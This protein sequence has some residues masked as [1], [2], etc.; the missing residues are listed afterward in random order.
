MTRPAG[1]RGGRSWAATGKDT[2][3]LRH[4]ARLLAHPARE[5]LRVLSDLVAGAPRAGE[6][7]DTD[8]R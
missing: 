4:L 3:G 1:E 8:G 6:D 2:K 5:L 7:T